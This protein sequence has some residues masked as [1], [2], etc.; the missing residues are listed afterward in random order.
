LAPLTCHWQINGDWPAMVALNVTLMPL[1]TVWLDGWVIKNGQES[2]AR[3]LI[4]FVPFG[5]PR[6]VQ[7]S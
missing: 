7:R 2:G 1:V 5:V 4:R 3:A 6:P